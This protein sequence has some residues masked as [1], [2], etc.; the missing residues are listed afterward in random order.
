[1]E[2]LKVKDFDFRDDQSYL[3]YRRDILYCAY[4]KCTE[5]DESSCELL[6]NTNNKW[7][8]CMKKR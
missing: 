1:M 7:L 8:M 6:I 5:C 2:S 4:R 3:K